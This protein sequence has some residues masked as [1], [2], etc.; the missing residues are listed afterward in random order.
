MRI[1]LI[2]AAYPPLNT[3]GIARQ[4][5]TLA[6]ELAHAGHDIHV[7]TFGT[8]TK[9]SLEQGVWVHRVDI[10]KSPNSFSKKY[11]GLDDPLT[12]SQALYEG[13][14][15]ALTKST[16]DIIDS[17]LWGARGIVTQQNVPTPTVIWLQ[18]TTAQV[19]K[20]QG[21]GPSSDEIAQLELETLSLQRADGILGDS[22]SIIDE[23]RRDYRLN[24]DIPVRIAHLGLPPIPIHH[25]RTNRNKVTAL[26]VGR[27]EKRKGTHLLYKII[28]QLLVDYPQLVIRFIGRDNSRSDGYDVSY[29]DYFNQEF[30][31][32]ADRVFF[33]G[34]VDEQILQEK[35]KQADMVL[36]P[37]LY[38]SF[39]FVFLE[40]MRAE[41]PVVAFKAGAASEIFQ[42]NE[43]DG[44]ILVKQGDLEEFSSAIRR[45]IEDA[46]FRKEIGRNGLKRFKNTFTAEKMAQ[47]TLSFYESVIKWKKMQGLQGEKIYQ[48]M[49]SLDY[50]D[51]VS[52]ITIRNAE[53]LEGLGQ[54]R[55]VLSRYA[56]DAV[57]HYTQPR[58]KIL[59]DPYAHLIFHFWHYSH[60]TWMLSSA[61]GRK[62]LYYHNITP[63]EF[64]DA[65]SAT[66]KMIKKGYEQ[67]EKI[68]DRFNLLIGDS[69]YNI[70]QLTPYLT[71]PRPGIVIHP[72]I[73]PE[74]LLSAAYDSTFAA[75][76]RRG[77]PINILFMGRIARNKRQDQ[78]MRVFDYYYQNMNR[79]AHLWLVGNENSDRTYREEL[80]RLRLSLISWDHIH[81]TGKVSDETANAFYRSADIFLSA[82]EHEGFGMPL[83]EAMA[84]GIPVLALART[85]IPETMG[86]AGILINEWDVPKIAELINIFLEN[87]DLRQKLLDGQIANLTRFSR[88]NAE[89]RMKAAVDYLLKR[90]KSP[91]FETFYPERHGERKSFTGT[92][93]RLFGNETQPVIPYLIAFTTRSGST[94]FCEYMTANG[95][96]RPAEYFQY[97]FGK[98]NYSVYKALGVSKRDFKGFLRE[99]IKQCS[100]NGIFG[101]KVLWDHKNALLERVQRYN[102][103]IR[104]I[105]DL[106]PDMK[107]IHI[108]RKDKVAQ[109]ISLW[110]AV[111]SGRWH[112]PD[113][114]NKKPNPKYN[115]YTIYSYYSS[116]I[117]E[118]QMWERYFEKRKL[119]V[120]S[121]LY[122]ELLDD[123]HKI[124]MQVADFIQAPASV[125]A[126]ETEVKIETHLKKLRDS[127]SQEIKARFLE[128]IDHIGTVEPWA[129]RHKTH[130]RWLDYIREKIPDK[131]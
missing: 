63:P 1:C 58:H 90:E 70:Q 45:L 10:Y 98:Q 125:L 36:L 30:P 3:E 122:E 120:Y 21:R 105:E 104:R 23:V 92:P 5:F 8:R 22:Q 19:L 2:S 51:A 129:G 95:L 25:D 15:A 116:I 94:L 50:G 27:L 20:I 109:A 83:I 117:A 96:G 76:L 28:P 101:A 113:H 31:Q 102:P 11:S 62:A 6:A 72:V 88:Q 26:V 108:Q 39:G 79:N 37:S 107:W 35:Y 53:I 4:R 57:R 99:L 41:L 84:F 33:D 66:H 74:K 54:P 42:K 75:Q 103:K 61:Q 48:V 130:G 24:P 124:I 115:F 43:Q 119:S 69:L 44:G 78:L 65:D 121:F 110:R 89:M 106:F 52:T 49:E 97:P 7:V 9:T 60:S 114:P 118:E 68:T 56:H 59:T 126:N 80:E 128:D 67:L 64:F 127:Y 16:F 40:A 86:K 18:T 17:P 14:N 71:S 93:I 87:Q 38:E 81:F 47:E 131:K 100:P 111:H 91:L 13:I 112:S 55:E 73:E 12:K 123:P 46:H 32:L 29:P 85:A 34:Y 77:N 82:S